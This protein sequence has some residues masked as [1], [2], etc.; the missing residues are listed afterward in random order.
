[1]LSS[2]L[3]RRWLVMA[4]LALAACGPQAEQSAD[5]ASGGAS[6]TF[7]PPAAGADS[8]VAADGGSGVATS[9]AVGARGQAGRA[10]SA[11]EPAAAADPEAGESPRPGASAEPAARPGHSRE[12][13]APHDDVLAPELADAAALHALGAWERLPVLGAGRYQQ[14]S[15]RDRN[16]PDEPDES[17]DPMFRHGNRDL[18]NFICK[19]TD[20]QLGEVHGLPLRFDRET[21][22]E[23]YV[24]GAVIARYEGSGVLRRFWLTAAA[25]LWGGGLTTE[26]LRIYVDDN[27]RPIV[28]LP[29]AQVMSGQA[30]EVFAPP[31]GAG[32][33][34]FVAWYYPVV[35]AKKLVV[36]LDDLP[37][38]YYFQTDA[39]LDREPRVRFA[40]AERLPERDRAIRLL[41]AAS[42]V[43][44]GAAGL[45]RES[46]RLNPDERR[47]VTLP[48]PATIEQLRLRAPSAML[49]SLAGVRVSVRWDGAQQ[50]ALDLPLLELFAAGRSVVARSAL[51]LAASTDG[52]D[53]L[54]SLRLPMPFAQRAQWEL[55][56]TSAAAVSFELDWS[57]VRTVPDAAYGHLHAQR[58]ELPLP[59]A[60]LE[61]TFAQAGRRGRYIGMCA[62]VAGTPDPNFVVSAPL[63]L[64]EGDVR[65]EA[66]GALALD[67]TG[68]EDYPDN[69]FYFLD[70]PK[71]TPFAQSWAVTGST[72]SLQPT[73][74]ASFCRWQVLGNELDFR[75]SFKGTFEIAQHDTA[76]VQLHRTLAFLYLARE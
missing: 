68:T 49:A 40:P 76:I 16:W 31:F 43:S 24:R 2:L 7:A 1:M 30:G 56:N 29:L 32:S 10:A 19:S 20:A 72:P 22:E 14:Q 51:A 38:E 52:A 25:L 28:Q 11:A 64:L 67:G 15:S 5:A 39:V 36:A 58:D 6:A 12:V 66:D 13:P 70:T 41:T 21:C 53:Q 61:Q 8:F 18:N 9:A 50:P 48:G 3:V 69:S 65:A 44:Q 37:S 4:S 62:D 47:G 23:A 27:P 17:L 35:F 33:R 54:L 42:P 57:G 63:H 26:R 75:G 74:T 71:A 60:Q 55:H 45:A 73:G 59:A 46:L 34:T